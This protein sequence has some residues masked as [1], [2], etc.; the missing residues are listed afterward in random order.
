MIVDVGS[1]S[2]TDCLRSF[3]RELGKIRQLLMIRS[4]IGKAQFMLRIVLALLCIPDLLD[5]SIP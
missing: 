3:I 1:I 4:W 5:P 2:T